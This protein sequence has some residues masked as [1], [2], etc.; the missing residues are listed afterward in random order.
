MR[1]GGGQGQKQANSVRGQNLMT[2]KNTAEAYQPRHIAGKANRTT[3]S[4]QEKM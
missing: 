2:F 3:W 4:C 1:T